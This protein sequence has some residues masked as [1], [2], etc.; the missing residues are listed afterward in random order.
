M[1]VLGVGTGGVGLVVIGACAVAGGI[2]GGIF[3]GWMGGN[4]LASGGTGWV[5]L[6]VAAGLGAVASWAVGTGTGLGA[7]YV[8]DKVND[9]NRK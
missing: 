3:G 2:G 8:Y 5:V 6:G 4:S 9:R 1:L 7:E